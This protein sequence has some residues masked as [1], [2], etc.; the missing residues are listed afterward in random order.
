MI[1][2]QRRS[3]RFAGNY[4]HLAHNPFQSPAQRP[5]A[6]CPSDLGTGEVMQPEPDDF[7]C[8]SHPCEGARLQ[9]CQKDVLNERD[10]ALAPCRSFGLAKNQHV[11][12]SLTRRR[13]R[14]ILINRQRTASHA[15]PRG[16]FV[17]PKIFP[18][19]LPIITSEKRTINS[20]CSPGSSPE[21]ASLP[22]PP[23]RR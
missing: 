20:E 6:P 7:K 19:V 4:D 21:P 12:S 8:R 23:H 22:R 11:V 17:H 13:P 3:P 10:G 9:S 2:P 18:A 15:G 1:Q 5:G 16:T 14:S